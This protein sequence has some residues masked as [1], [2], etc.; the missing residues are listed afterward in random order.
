LFLVVP[1]GLK[2]LHEK[3]TIVVYFEALTKN[4]Y[5]ELE[6]NHGKDRIGSDLANT[7]T[8]YHANSSAV[9]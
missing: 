7:S 8:G 4:S 9:G 2:L 3:K 5:R 1:V 6:A